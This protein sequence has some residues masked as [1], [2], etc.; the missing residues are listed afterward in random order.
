MKA[1]L[2]NVASEYYRIARLYMIRLAKGD[3]DDPH[4]LAKLA[5]V[6]NCTVDNFRSQFYHVIENDIL[7]RLGKP[8]PKHV[9]TNHA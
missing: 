6:A 1:R 9:P 3:F 8:I 7:L 5:A 2:V 4:E